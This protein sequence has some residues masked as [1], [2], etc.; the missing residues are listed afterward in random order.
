M[1]IFLLDLSI[2]MCFI[3]F[4]FNFERVHLAMKGCTCVLRGC[5]RT[6]K[7]PNSPP[8]GLGLLSIIGTDW[9]QIRTEKRIPMYTKTNALISERVINPLKMAFRILPVSRRKV[10]R[11]LRGSRT[12]AKLE[13]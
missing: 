1:I 6:L 12:S 13:V 11:R 3:N 9:V 7:T 4:F 5:S 8:L 10:R 2:K